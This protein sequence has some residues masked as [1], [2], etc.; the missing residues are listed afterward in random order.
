MPEGKD[1]AFGFTKAD[2]T[3]VGKTV[4]AYE[5]DPQGG[6]PYR[7]KGRARGK[8]GGT[9]TVP[10]KIKSQVAYNNYTADVYADGTDAAATDTDVTVMVLE[11]ATT[12]T[13]PND[14]YFF[15]RKLAWS[16]TKEWTIEVPRSL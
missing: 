14:R 5:G 7:N 13:V 9:T 16:G 12:E 1:R 4:I 11:I 3:R 15:A 2:H 8:G 6:N 10:I